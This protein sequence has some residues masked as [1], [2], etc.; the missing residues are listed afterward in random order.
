[1]SP[2]TTSDIEKKN[3]NSST[4][5]YLNAATL[6]ESST[7]PLPPLPPQPPQPALPLKSTESLSSS[8]N[9]EW[10]PER[11]VSVN[12]TSGQGLGISIVGGKINPELGG[13]S[14]TG[15]FIKHVL[16]GSPAGNTG[17]LCT[18]DRILQVDG[19][20]LRHASHEK[21][22]EI[23]RQ[24][25]NSVEFVVQS[26]LADDDDED[27]D[28]DDEDEDACDDVEEVKDNMEPPP[29]FANDLEP[30][31]PPE[32]LSEP[33]L[34]PLPEPPQESPPTEPLPEEP[35]QPPPEIGKF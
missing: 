14:V 31:L 28:E 27:D 12:R 13:E 9:N 35:L 8:G 7:D 32:P 19:V 11:H 1:M 3:S 22:V 29:E 5:V 20:D 25:G 10:G 16:D 23:I 2:E 18:G 21:A 24:T 30:P 6:D 26:L 4:T 33:P 34:E 17:Q 15:I